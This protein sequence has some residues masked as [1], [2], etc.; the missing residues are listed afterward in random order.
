MQE[1]WLSIDQPVLWQTLR[2]SALAPLFK[3][4][5][6]NFR[7]G[8]EFSHGENKLAIE[9][10]GFPVGDTLLGGI[11]ITGRKLQAGRTER[12]RLCAY[13]DLQED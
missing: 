9:L 7:I 13:E 10:E 1:I 4:L 2:I 12:S 5:H 6:A 11:P 3:H 8:G